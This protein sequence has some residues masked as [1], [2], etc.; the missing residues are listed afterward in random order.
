MRSMVCMIDWRRVQQARASVGCEDV[1]G[2]LPEESLESSVF[3]VMVAFIL[4]DLSS[5][6]RRTVPYLELCV[7]VC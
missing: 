2:R 7:E 5:I 3:V 4:I 1:D 6:T